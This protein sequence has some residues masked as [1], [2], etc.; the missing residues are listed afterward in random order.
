MTNT[1]EVPQDYLACPETKTL[2]LQE[3]L[4]STAS[5]KLGTTDAIQCSSLVSAV[6]IV[7]GHFN[8]AETLTLVTLFPPDQAYHHSGHVN[9]SKD[10]RP[11]IL[12]TAV[13]A[14]TAESSALIVD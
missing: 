9:D 13:D 14:A 10:A 6:Q 4:I 3:H 2:V 12:V 1:P 5:F 11:A 8:A 7:Q